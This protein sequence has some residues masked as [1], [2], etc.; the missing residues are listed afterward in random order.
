[1]KLKKTLPFIAALA[2]AA[3]FA[4]TAEAKEKVIIPDYECMI[5]DSSV[6][7]K[8]SVYP[9]LSYKDV[10]YFPL[11]YDYCRSLNLT[12]SFSES[13]GLFI[14]YIPTYN[15]SLPVYDTTV[16]PVY[17]EAELPEYPIYINGRKIDNSKE[18]Y[19]LLNFRGVTYFPMTYSFAVNDFGWS[20]NWE[21]GKFTIKTDYRTPLIGQISIIERASDSVVFGF[22]KSYYTSYL[23][24]AFSSD[25]CDYYKKLDLKAGTLTE[26]EGYTRPEQSASSTVFDAEVTYDKETNEVRAFGALLPE[27]NDFTRFDPADFAQSGVSVSGYGE[28]VDGVD[29]IEVTERFSGWYADGSGMGTRYQY[30]YIV[31]DKTPYFIGN[32]LIPVSVVKTDSG[33]YFTVRRYGQ[34]TFRHF[35]SNTI[36]YKLADGRVTNVT[37]SFPDH[38]SVSLLGAVGS[39]LYLKCEW[40]PS[41]MLAENCYHDVSAVNDGYFTYDG[42][43]L[44]RLAPY[45]YSDF[46]ILSP[47]GDIWQVTGYNM[48]IKK[49]EPFAP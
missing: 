16:N 41:P 12:S 10:T 21:P 29:F 30:L 5:N 11:T 7:Y 31:V 4:C 20:T 47:D 8:D 27:V 43:T 2:A 44:T 36:L 34:T 24:G 42:E 9:L 17:N 46:D 32:E 22:H 48:T 49:A 13:E 6:Y 18:E 39:T 15:N 40:C 26:L 23:S 33:T 25:E 38:N 1:M 19:P 35:F 14:S 37:D 3:T 28:T 45:S